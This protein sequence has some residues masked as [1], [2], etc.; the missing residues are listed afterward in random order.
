MTDFE[1]IKLI[2]T[3][4]EADFSSMNLYH[5][6]LSPQ[7]I[8]YLIQHKFINLQGISATHLPSTFVQQYQAYLDIKSRQRPE[9]FSVNDAVHSA[10]KRF[11]TEQTGATCSL[12]K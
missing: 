2:G 4:E 8:T 9:F 1:T 5:A 3:V 10:S 7:A 6:V 11:C 12:K